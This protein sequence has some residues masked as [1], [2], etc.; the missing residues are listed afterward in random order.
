G[1]FIGNIA[2]RLIVIALIEL[3]LH[4]FS[5][6]FVPQL[7]DRALG[8]EILGFSV[9]LVVVTLLLWGLSSSNRFFI[10][11]FVGY[12]ENG[13]FSVAQKFAAILETLALIFY[14]AW[15]ETAIKQYDDS[16]R[17]AFYSRILNIYIWFLTLLVVVVSY[18]VNLLYGWIVS[19]EY[20]ESRFYLYPLLSSSMLVSL[21]FFYDVGY[22][23]V[24]KTVRELPGLV[25]A[26]AISLAGNFFFVQ[27]WGVYGILATLNL[28]YLV[29]IAIRIADTKKYIRLTLTW[30][31]FLSMAVLVAAG[32]F[33]YILPGK[34]E[35]FAFGVLMSVV[36][37]ACVPPEIIKM[38][39]SKIKPS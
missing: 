13:L 6:Y 25:I 22:Q 3:R 10:Q 9:P 2:A 8:R 36:L 35:N 38:V 28:S 31:S 14:Q 26:L 37:L 11:H 17:N 27:W 24:K 39:L 32:V 30:R 21:C 1:I 18:G 29:L 23:C 4:L 16:D 7:H 12:S 15:Q 19:A 5:R 33:Y 34:L 20:Q